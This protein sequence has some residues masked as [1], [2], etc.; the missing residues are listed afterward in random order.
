M[1]PF[2]EPGP[3]AANVPPS[4]GA[5]QPSSRSAI[6]PAAA[7]P[8]AL[9][10]HR[11]RG[12]RGAGSG[13]AA[14][15]AAGV[16]RFLRGPG[17]LPRHPRA[18]GPARAGRRRLLAGDPRRCAPLRGRFR[19]RRL[20]LARL[21]ADRAREHPRRRHTPTCLCRLRAP[22][23]G[24]PSAQSSSLGLPPPSV[25]TELQRGVPAPA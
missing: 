18:L 15:G 24:L 23:V 17:S 5:P 13:K 4:P 21:Q 9:S 19:P 8:T 10:R 14:W 25:R 2:P 20:L 6:S 3:G 22:V 11:R 16:V 7:W 1:G 12:G